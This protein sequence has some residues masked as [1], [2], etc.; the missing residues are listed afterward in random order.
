M[1]GVVPAS[2][3]GVKVF[4]DEMPDGFYSEGERPFSG[5]DIRLDCAGESKNIATDENGVAFFPIVPSGE[6]TITCTLPQ[7][8]VFS[9]SAEGENANFLYSDV[10]SSKLSRVIKIEPETDSSFFIAVTLPSSISGAVFD[11]AN[12][13]GIYDEGEG[14]IEGVEIHAVN[15]AGNI[16]SSATSD[17]NGNYTLSNL[18]PSEYKVRFVIKSPYIFSDTSNTGVAMEIK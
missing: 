16:V 18:L 1:V 9:V 7:G 2:S 8:Q 15:S 12:I 11:D 10:A 3:I 13:S 14:F 17:E 5:A 6:A 4:H